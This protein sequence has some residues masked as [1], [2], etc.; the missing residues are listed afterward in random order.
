MLIN[1]HRFVYGVVAVG[2][3]IFPKCLQG[4]TDNYLIYIQR[5]CYICVCVKFVEIRLVST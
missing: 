1:Y 5:H 4:E 3:I 2:R